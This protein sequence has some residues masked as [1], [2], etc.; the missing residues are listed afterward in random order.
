MRQLV[1]QFLAK[2]MFEV[3]FSRRQPLSETGLTAFYFGK[4][5]IAISEDHLRKNNDDDARRKVEMHLRP[6]PQSCAPHAAM[7]RE[8]IRYSRLMAGRF[9]S[10]RA[11]AQGIFG[12]GVSE[13]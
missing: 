11:C 13:G 2:T 3:R 5:A 9:T 7:F 12:D 4:M 8:R 1:E 6:A 10:E